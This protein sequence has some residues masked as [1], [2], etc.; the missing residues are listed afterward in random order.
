MSLLELRQMYFTRRNGVCRQFDYKLYN[1]LCITMKFPNAYEFVGAIWI[2]ASIMKIHAQAFANLLGVHTVQGALFHKQGNFARHGFTHVFRQ[3]AP[4]L[5]DCDNV[6]DYN[7]R[8]YIDRSQ[9]FLR[10]R[11]F[12][13]IPDSFH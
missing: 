10:G 11:E 2:S 8:L 6:D 9:R 12:Q 4:H 1:A 7:V 5:S 13:P 3:S